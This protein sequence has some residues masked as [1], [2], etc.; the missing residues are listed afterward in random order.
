MSK[1]LPFDDAL[2]LAQSLGLANSREWNEWSKEGMRPANVPST[3]QQSYKHDGWQGWGHWL[4]T[5]NLATQTMQFLPFDEAL[6][7]ARALRLVSS[8]EWHTWCKSGARPANVP[9][10][11]D[12]TYRH[13]G[14]RGYE[15]WLRHTNPA[16]AAAP[17]RNT[18]RPSKKRAAAS[19]AAPRGR[20]VQQRR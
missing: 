15:H 7:V 13:E 3:P 5:G 18:A 2:L 20:C 19:N 1:F 4:G 8:A 6:L 9:S 12:A 10:N 17:S 11:P 14:W 16:A